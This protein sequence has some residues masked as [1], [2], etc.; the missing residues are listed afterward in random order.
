MKTYPK[1]L[2]VI[3]AIL[4]IWGINDFVCYYKYGIDTINQF[5]GTGAEFTIKEMVY[6][7]LQNGVIKTLLAILTFILPLIKTRR[8]K[9]DK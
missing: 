5:L 6:G 3:F 7:N 1:F 2:V 4:L 9:A 8:N